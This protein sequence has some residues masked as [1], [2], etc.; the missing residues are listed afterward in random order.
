MTMQR[1]MK[2]YRLPEASGAP[3]PGQEREGGLETGRAWCGL[4][5]GQGALLPEKQPSPWF[6]DSWPCPFCPPLICS[7]GFILV[8]LSVFLSLHLDLLLC[9]LLADSESAYSVISA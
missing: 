7:L 3:G 2:L 5:Q 4:S 1:T 8:G 6:P 9:H